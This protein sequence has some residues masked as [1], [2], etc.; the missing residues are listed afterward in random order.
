MPNEPQREASNLVAA[1]T[2]VLFIG[3]VA[4]WA[5]IAEQLFR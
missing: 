1:V 3:V 5:N 4:I 2:I